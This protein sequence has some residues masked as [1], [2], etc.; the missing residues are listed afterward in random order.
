[1]VDLRAVLQDASELLME[2]LELYRDTRENVLADTGSPTAVDFS[3][4]D[5]ALKERALRER[6][7]IDGNLHP[8]LE[9]SGGEYKML[10]AVSDGLVG[11]LLDPRDAN[12]VAS[13]AVARELMAACVLR[14]LMMWSSPYYVNKGMYRMLERH[15]ERRQRRTPEAD[16]IPAPDA[17]RRRE[18]HG[19][20]EFEQRIVKT[21]QDEA[22]LLVQGGKCECNGMPL[23]SSLALGLPHGRSRSYDD[24]HISMATPSSRERMHPVR[25]GLETNNNNSNNSGGGVAPCS[26]APTSNGSHVEDRTS[27]TSS[28][29]ATSPMRSLTQSMHEGREKSAQNESL[30]SQYETTYTLDGSPFDQNGSFSSPLRVDNVDQH[31]SFSAAAGHLIA[32]SERKG[33]RWCECYDDGFIG[34]PRARVVAADLNTSGAKDFVVYRIRVGDDGGGGRE[35]T[36]SRRYRHFEVLHRQLRSLSGYASK[37]P[38]KRIFFHTQNADFVE[39]RRRALDAFLQEVLQVPQLAR[40]KDLWEFLR[41]GSE[42]YES[43]SSFEYRGGVGVDGRQRSGIRRGLS[44]TMLAG[45]QSLGRGAESE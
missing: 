1:M 28:M 44:R 40:S 5:P 41:S 16:K 39:D 11:L 3:S 4:G 35:W 37:L 25:G 2:Q 42:R 33:T 38:P 20:W 26:W 27:R 19:T 6:M 31:D 17:L 24:V 36:A 23:Q 10:R 43:L 32:R 30:V 13:R 14:P 29:S 22:T 9:Q 45:A 34:S 7:S 12:R 18:L 15:A 8:A 21:V